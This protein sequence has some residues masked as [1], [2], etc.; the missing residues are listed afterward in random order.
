MIIWLFSC[1][2]LSFQSSLLFS[3]HC[4]ISTEREIEVS[5]CNLISY[6]LG[7]FL[8]DLWWGSKG[9]K[10]QKIKK[11]KFWFSDRCKTKANKK[12]KFTQIANKNPKRPSCLSHDWA[13]SS[14]NLLINVWKIAFLRSIGISMMMKW[15][16]IR[17]IF[18]RATPTTPF[19]RT[20]C[21]CFLT[22]HCVHLPE[23]I[24]SVAPVNPFRFIPP[25]DLDSS[26]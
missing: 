17:G 3:I 21:S 24:Y 5:S 12:Y 4:G 25:I 13:K 22:W 2:C 19:W 7:L 23:L 14:V 15:R 8:T 1:L 11:S 9:K 18:F 20:A 6:Y 26:L 10:N 16:L